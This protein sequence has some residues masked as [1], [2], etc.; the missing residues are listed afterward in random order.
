MGR[1]PSRSMGISTELTGGL[2]QRCCSLVPTRAHTAAHTLV[3]ACPHSTPGKAGSMPSSRVGK[4]RPQISTYPGSEG[5]GLTPPDHTSPW[6]GLPTPQS[7]CSGQPC[8][9]SDLG[10][11]RRSRWRA[12]GRRGP[13]HLVL[14]S[15]YHL[16]QPPPHHPLLGRDSCI[17]GFHTKLAASTPAEGHRMGIRS[18]VGGLPRGVDWSLNLARQPTPPPTPR[19]TIFPPAPQQDLP[20]P[21]V[22]LPSPPACAPS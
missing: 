13:T 7:S 9:G 20:S 15:V 8:L 12:V 18:I 4:S 5:L 22:G 21:E 6:L 14:N 2:L 19:K 3:P 17:P 11:A 16:V 1:L 10:L